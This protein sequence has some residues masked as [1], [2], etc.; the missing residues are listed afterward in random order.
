MDR[1]PILAMSAVPSVI[2]A[3]A[4]IGEPYVMP[5]IPDLDHFLATEGRRVRV[6]VQLGRVFA[7]D[8]LFGALPALGLVAIAGAGHEGIDIKKLSARG[9][10]VT[11]GRGAN[12]DDVAD[13]ALGL[14]LAVLRRIVS[15]SQLIRNGNWR[16]HP[17]FPTP[18]RSMS[19]MRFGIVGLGAIGRAIAHRL[20]PFGGEISWWGPRDKPGVP[21]P[22]AF[23]LRQLAETSDMLVVAA[24]AGSDTHHLI[25][26]EIL[27][28]MAPGSHLVNVSRGSLVDQDALYDALRSGRLAGAGLDVFDSEPFH[29]AAWDELPNVVMTPHIGGWAEAAMRRTRETLIANIAA[30]FEGR[31]LLTPLEPLAGA[32]AA[33][34]P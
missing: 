26:A 8:R 22:R 12:A 31:P 15:G 7:E 34:H 29:D 2:E 18:S 24:P 10:A 20:A 19:D 9:I 11:T 4:T 23:S 16:A 17:S 1:E 25:D 3:L 27:T 30:F 13:I 28:A 5:Q 6:L 33:S 14:I 21:W 32:A